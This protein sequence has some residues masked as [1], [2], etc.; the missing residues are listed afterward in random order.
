MPNEVIGNIRESF[1]FGIIGPAL[2]TIS[3]VLYFVL[4]IGIRWSRRLDQVYLPNGSFYAAA[5]TVAFAAFSISVMMPIEVSANRATNELAANGLQSLVRAARTN[6]AAYDGFYPGMN[7]REAIAIA[8]AQVVQSNTRFLTSEDNRSLLRHIDNG[9]SPKRLNVV[10]VLAESFG[11]VLVD[12]LDLWVPGESVSPNVTS[13]GRQGLYFTNVHS[14]GLRTVRG[15]EAILTSFPPIPGISTTRRPGSEGMHSLPFILRDQG[16]ATGFLYGGNLMFDNMATFLG[17]IGFEHLWGR[18]DIAE[19]GFTTAWGAADEYIFGEALRRLDTL[20]ADSRPAFLSIL[21]VSNHR[22]FSFPAGRIAKDPLAKRRENATTYADWAFGEFIK[23]ARSRPW[24]ANTVFIFI[25]DHGP[26]VAGAAQ[27]P[28]DRYRIPLFFYAP[29]HIA[30]ARIATV[31]SS[32]DLAPTLLGILGI[33]YDS[34]FFGVDLLRVPEGQGRAF[35]DH[36]YVV[37]LAKGDHLVTLEPNRRTR[38][39]PYK[40]GPKPL[41][42][43]EAPDPETLRTAIA[44][45]QTA[46]HMFYAGEYHR[47]VPT[48]IV[49][50]KP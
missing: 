33:S 42:A 46:H 18:P 48:R 32:M 19:V 39:Y 1:N 5:L 15:L 22:P 12:D 50:A 25:A 2:V 49:P 17:G 11:S 8:R 41:P 35:M 44:V 9:N 14:T 6:D 43:E 34:P 4:H 45:I 31:G 3:L 30:P 16:Y 47:V 36:N 10:L 13:L 40:P 27:V 7:E 21:T 29:A 38:G 24:F 20:T 23:Q 28:I 37:A 26:Y